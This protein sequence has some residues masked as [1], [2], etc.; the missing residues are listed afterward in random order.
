MK[1]STAD[2]GQPPRQPEIFQ[3]PVFNQTPNQGATTRPHAPLP[4]T[5]TTVQRPAVAIWPEPSQATCT[6]STNQAYP[7]GPPGLPASPPTFHDFRPTTE[8]PSIILRSREGSNPTGRHALSQVTGKTELI[9]RRTTA[10]DP[11][12]LADTPRR[13]TTVT[14]S[15]VEIWCPQEL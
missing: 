3:I 10:D 11:I 14:K 7:P 4:P 13:P 6:F 8:R 2:A 1:R 12:E 15:S 9:V 5:M